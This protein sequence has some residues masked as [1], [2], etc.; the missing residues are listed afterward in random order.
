MGG[1]THLS[2]AASYLLCF[3][4]YR[5]AA[6]SPELA[7]AVTPLPACPPCQPLRGAPDAL[8]GAASRPS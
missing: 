2:E 5:S 4:T 6:T 8:T 7:A 3:R 1:D